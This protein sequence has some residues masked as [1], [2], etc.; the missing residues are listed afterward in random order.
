VERRLSL[1]P[2]SRAPRAPAGVT[3]SHTDGSARSTID[4]AKLKIVAV[5]GP[6]PTAP[7]GAARVAK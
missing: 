5:T 4:G 2:W 6:A 7:K 1:A 3:S